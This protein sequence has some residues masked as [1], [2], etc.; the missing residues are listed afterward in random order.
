MELEAGGRRRPR[1]RHGDRLNHV[2]GG[3]GSY[4]ELLY[5]SV[6]LIAL[7]GL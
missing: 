5:L 4:L 1:L 6:A 7:A 3:R 2:G